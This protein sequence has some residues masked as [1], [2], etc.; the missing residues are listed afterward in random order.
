MRA[1]LAQALL[2]VR[3]FVE[4][5]RSLSTLS[6]A[7]PSQALWN[8]EHAD[9][10]LPPDVTAALVELLDMTHRYDDATDLWGRTTYEGDD[11]RRD[12]QVL[13]ALEKCAPDPALVPTLA[14]M[15]AGATY[16][17][18]YAQPGGT[19][20]I[21]KY[22]RD[23]SVESAQ[24][25]LARACASLLGRLPLEAPA[26]EALEGACRHRSDEVRS[27]ARAALRRPG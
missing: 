19:P 24:D 12:A 17:R 20:D 18:Y 13:R 27:V 14:S 8:I 7:F 22:D 11:L 23:S 16:D 26:R 2:D 1:A 21:D 5:N 4:R 15:L 25:H 3:A 9:E 6:E 10:P